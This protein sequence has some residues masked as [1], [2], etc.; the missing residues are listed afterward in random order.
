[1]DSELD[2]LQ[3]RLQEMVIADAREVYSER[4]I[5]HAMNPRNVGVI[6]GADGYGSA[7]GIC[8][9][10]MEIWLRV[11]NDVV[12]DARFWT[13]GC[14][15]TIASGSAITELAKGKTALEALS[16]AQKDVLTALDGL[17]ADSEHC[18]TLAANA[19]HQAIQEYLTLKR[20]PW[21]KPYREY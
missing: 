8:G 10:S 6:Q 18:A 4:T 13:D 11:R 3:Q 15:T 16:I 7:L 17:P 1:M 19:L 2:E 20:E 14:A 12:T 21:R 9:D 5:D